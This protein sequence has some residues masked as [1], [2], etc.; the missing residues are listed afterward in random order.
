M[1]TAHVIN[2]KQLCL[3]AAAASLA[4]TSG[5]AFAQYIGPTA[6]AGPSKNIKQI[7][8]NPD[9]DERVSMQGLLLRRTG[10][11]KY[12]FTDGTG[13]IT[14]DIDKDNFVRQPVDEKT[15]VEIHGEVDTGLRRPPEIDVESMRV[16]PAAQ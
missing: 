5:I 1:R 11:E 4:F 9:D 13:E 14:V 15:R 7:L 3:M 16:L 8:E 12:V 2:R 6:G 10:D